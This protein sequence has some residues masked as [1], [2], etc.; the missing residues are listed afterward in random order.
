MTNNHLRRADLQLIAIFFFLLIPVLAIAAP[1]KT[2]AA[3]VVRQ[4]AQ[5]FQQSCGFCHGPDATGARGPDLVRS[6]VV[7]DDENGNLIGDVI[8]QGRP[9]KGMPALPLN[10]SQIQ[11][12]AAYLHDRA[13]EGLE[14]ARLP[15]EYP[16]S[17][18]LTGNAEA[19]KAYFEGAGGCKTCHSPTGDLKGV[20]SKYSPLELE[21]QMLYPE[22]APPTTVTAVLPSGERVKGILEHFDEF[23]VALRD[24][25]G[26]QRSFSRDEVMLE[27]DDPLGAH[28]KL[29]VKIS[30][31]ELHDLFAYMETLK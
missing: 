28:K 22:H 15:K 21:A 26:W 8:R 23:T 7:A 5:Q 11:A 10:S 14:S 27:M 3:D 20:A 13:R 30:E 29:L 17:K 24:D 18:L 25:S 19:G 9:D 1:Q 12:I 2:A 4:G 6:K 16:L 31:K